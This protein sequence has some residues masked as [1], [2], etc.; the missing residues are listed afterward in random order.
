MLRFIP[1]SPTGAVTGKVGIGISSVI[2]PTGP[3]GSD[4]PVGPT[5]SDGPIGPTGPGSGSSLPSGTSYADYLI[6]DGTGS[7]IVQSTNVNLGANSGYI[8]QT[9]NNVAIGYYAGATGQ[10]HQSTSPFNSGTGSAIAI[11]NYAG[12]NQACSS[13]AIGNYAGYYQKEANI[14]IGIFAG[15]EQSEINNIAIG[16]YAGSQSQGTGGELNANGG[17]SI[18]IGS[19]CGA[20]NQSYECV[21]IGLSAG[22]EFQNNNSIAI[23]VNAGQTNQGSNSIAIGQSAGETNQGSNSII[24]N[25][26]SNALNAST[27]GLFI[28]PIRNTTGPNS[29]FYNP[30]TKEITYSTLSEGPTGPQGVAG[31]TGPQGVAGPTGPQGLQGVGAGSSTGSWTVSA[32][33]GT[34][35]FTVTQNNTYVMWVRGNIPNGIIVWNATV[36]VTNSNVPV[37]GSQ[38]AWYYT[39]GNALVLTSIPSQI[40][41]TAGSIITTNP[42]TPSSNVFSFNITNNSGLSQIV[43][44]GY[45]KL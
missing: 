26:D 18:A 29:L 44:Y 14:A 13:I 30:S 3:T 38:Y 27:S 6:W 28:N 22:Y 15:Y 2:G 5:G 7:Y 12:A 32:G 25:A 45:I 4:G 33:A 11:G 39:D 16:I 35:N 21:A 8:D 41:G 17:N 20:I 34:Y 40:I 43:E 10:G 1:N 19:N 42:V 36:S 37:I 23:G 24:L 31:P 9:H